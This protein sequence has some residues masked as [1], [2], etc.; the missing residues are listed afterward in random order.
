VRTR[1]GEVASLETD[2]VSLQALDWRVESLQ[3]LSLR[4]GSGQGL[5]ALLGSPLPPRLTELALGNAMG[6]LGAEG[7][8]SLATSPQLGQLATLRLCGHHVGAEGVEVLLTSPQLTSLTRL[9]LRNNKLRAK[10]LCAVS[11]SPHR[12]SLADLDLGG[13]PIGNRGCQALADWACLGPLTKLGLADCEIKDAGAI[14]LANSPHLAHIDRIEL[15]SNPIGA[16]GLRE[17]RTRFGERAVL[18]G[19]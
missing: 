13:N 17:L 1:S 10:D 16:E 14:A 3:S 15:M 5:V 12:M 2:L 9:D 4:G 6:S 7:A 18:D 11:P 8:R 19:G